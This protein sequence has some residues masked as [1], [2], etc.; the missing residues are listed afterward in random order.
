MLR[1]V[2][3]LAACLALVARCTPVQDDI[4]SVNFGDEVQLRQDLL[5]SFAYAARPAAT[6]IGAIDT[7]E[8]GTVQPAVPGVWRWISDN[9]IVF[10]PRPGFQPATAYTLS[11]ASSLFAADTT[12]EYGRPGGTWSFHTPSQAIVSTTAT[13][14]LNAITQQPVL[15]INVGLVYDVNL[16]DV[17]P[18]T[19]C[20]VNGAAI[21]VAAN[22]EQGS[23][24]NVC[25]F[26]IPN[27]PDGVTGPLQLTIDKGLRSTQ[28]GNATESPLTANVTV[29][30]KSRLEVLEVTTSWVGSEGIIDVVT[31]Q[32]LDPTTLASG[33]Q[34]EP[35]IRHAVE[36]TATGC[37]LRAAF[38]VGKTYTVVVASSLRGDVG[39]TLAETARFPVS[40]A[41]LEPSIGFDNNRAI[42]LSARGSR[43]VGI[44]I[45]NVQRVRVSVFRVYENNVLHLLRS[46]RTYSWDEETET[47]VQG[48]NYRFDWIDL[49][50]F[51]D[52]VSSREYDVTHLGISPNGK[53]VLNLD[54]RQHA[55]HKG[56]YIVRCESAD[57]SWLNASKL[58]AISDV[59]L[60]AKQGND[61]LTIMAHSLQTAQPLANVSLTLH[62][63]NNQPIETVSTDGTGA[64]RI[65][66][67]RERFGRFSLGMITAQHDGEMTFL[68]LADTKVDRSRFETDGV[69]SNAAGLQAFLYGDRDVY[70]PGET[71]N[72][73]A[74]VRTDG[75]QT[76]ATVPLQIRFRKPDGT[77]Y[78]TVRVTPAEDGAAAVRLPIA[79][80]AMTG[81]WTIEALTA[82]GVQIGSTFVAVE[83]FMPDKL[84]VNITAS[85]QA[86]RPGDKL[87][88]SVNAATFYGVAASKRPY[89]M[90]L[91]I[92]PAEFI[93]KRFPDYT[94]S[95]ITDRESAV[96][97]L[98]KSGTLDEDGNATASFNIDGE[99]Q[100]MGPLRATL[101]CA[102]VD[103]SGRPI[104][105]GQ[106]IAVHTQ[107]AYFGI[108]PVDRYVDAGRTFTA[109]IVACN[110]DGAATTARA[111]VQLVRREYHTVLER[112]YGSS[113]RYV[114]Q[115]RDVVEQSSIVTVSGTGSTF[116]YKAT[117]S[118]DYE[119]RVAPEGGAA[120]VS[121][122]FYAFRW[123]MASA[124][125]FAVNTE[126]LIDITLDKDRYAV[127]D[128]ANVLFS[129]P[130]AG[131]LLVTVER[132][133]VMEHHVVK[134]DKRSAS[135]QLTVGDAWAP[136][137]YISAT[138]IKPHAQS[139]VPFTV[140]H[141]YAPLLVHRASSIL[142]VTI[143]A[144]A[145]SRSAQ[146][147]RVTVTT[148]PGAYVTIA[149]VDEG[150]LQL[151]N[152]ASPDPHKH[153]HRKRALEVNSYDMYAYLLPELSVLRAATGAGDDAG[154]RVNPF[155]SRRVQ[156]VS[157]W[158]GIIHA[159][160]GTATFD[161]D[162][163]TYAGE[164]RVMAVAWKGGAVGSAQQAMRVADPIV[165]QTAL[166]R[167]LAPGDTVVVPIHIH[168]TTGKGAS[169]DVRL[170][171]GG[172]LS[173]VGSAAQS[174]LLTANGQAHA[175][176]TVAVGNG[177]GAATV[178]ATAKAMGQTFTHRSEIAV[179]PAVPLIAT[180][181]EGVLDADKRT[182]VTVGSN[183]LP[184]L[185][186]VRVVVTGFPAAQIVSN[187]HELL[188]Y[189]HGCAEQTIAA[190]FPQLYVA[191][192]VRVWQ[193]SVQ[194]SYNIADAVQ[195]AI[196][197]VESMQG[198]NGGIHTWPGVAQPD[199]W[200]TA[201]AAHFLHEARTAG[202]EV[203]EQILNS[204]ATY[205]ARKARLRQVE[206]VWTLDG[207]TAKPSATRPARETFYTLFVLAA[208][209]KQDVPT[210]NSYKARPG[211]LSADSRYLLACTY[212]MLGDERSFA[213]LAQSDLQPED[214]N[215]YWGEAYASPVRD[216]ALGLYALAKV[217]PRDTRCQALARR[218]GT[219]MKKRRYLSTQERSF[220][221]M[222]LGLLARDAKGSTASATLQLDG[223][224]AA[225]MQG[226]PVVIT[227]KAGQ[228]LAIAAQ[229]G[230]VYYTVH[231]TGI[232]K[233]AASIPQEDVGL[234]VR[235]AYFTRDGKNADIGRVR[236]NDVLVVAITISTT[237]RSEIQQVAISDVLPAGFEIENPRLGA[238]GAGE[239]FR[240]SYTPVHYDY[241]DDRMNLYVTAT[242]K[243]RTYYYVVRAI[244]RGTFVHAP[245]G[246]DAMYEA[247]MRS[248]SGG[249]V[250]RV[251]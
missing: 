112:S 93:A 240:D 95:V 168:N 98:E 194:P 212:R 96:R 207:N 238:A 120:Y 84:R 154:L 139:D 118:G 4:V 131:T 108:G 129:T 200:T 109:S 90:S 134:T 130:F 29:P 68:P 159:K 115:R 229:G 27:M 199:W 49:E 69:L 55:R 65:D 56:V 105:R 191:D 76:P 161:M 236:Q 232:P 33:I 246:A 97:D 209:G 178:T 91:T 121:R 244:T 193:A 226:E 34:L 54:V 114:S 44:N 79:H 145:S 53:A 233:S 215:R 231:T 23:A 249:G 72:V 155:T 81:L 58:V 150:I 144:A 223:K 66:K 20:Q 186:T 248:Y 182:E 164:L 196:R 80:S 225:T 2:L 63:T 250:V 104:H 149:A 61:E 179:R 11:L 83:D 87:D 135:L 10:S 67:L 22:A 247:S 205:L 38:T 183:Y 166:P 103:E 132:S 32:S 234:R 102:V 185:S 6:R 30:D 16:A 206:T 133:G 18:L 224:T 101:Y 92:R 176:M 222:A 148:T 140:A 184:G 71:L 57:R 165:V 60:I 111:R 163:P 162:I 12:G 3:T 198:Y 243:P 86:A 228:K 74:L 218:L 113:Y 50:P 125:S 219:M 189:P 119:I 88:F 141:G 45:V 70:R 214:E 151:R 122:S 19:H 17:L 124:S 73:V 42:Y 51:A 25:S 173:V 136:N 100:N 110:A 241:R 77:E 138:L 47:E 170:T 15:Q 31:S 188:E 99:L 217:A 41:E 177:L 158:S 89:E 174:V 107:P 190:A 216:V 82:G 147:Q 192:L 221:V 202:Y 146:K 78:R 187:M 85:T 160:N 251:W 7:I 143:A 137:V 123:G 127:G 235:R 245:I 220:G 239:R 126:G 167:V 40:F 157:L 26:T 9:E 242:D 152:Y 116:S 36:R 75:M 5:F 213:Q 128:R 211:E 195:A 230:T 197:K 142:P 171:V 169:A 35:D 172:P 13:W 48:P 39:G 37:R 64:V 59:G 227:A 1:H 24:S 153:F 43:L 156:P 237:D 208:L 14:T 94:F 201:Y 8:Y 175:T 21:A 203:N 62:S 28:G 180:S 106:R 204:L 46:T 117:M 52:T 210:M 181:V